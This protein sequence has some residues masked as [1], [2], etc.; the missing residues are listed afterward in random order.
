M[1]NFQPVK[2]GTKGCLKQFQQAVEF[3]PQGCGFKTF[4]FNRNSDK[5]IWLEPPGFGDTTEQIM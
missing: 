1:L 2:I 3:S 5:R 4:E